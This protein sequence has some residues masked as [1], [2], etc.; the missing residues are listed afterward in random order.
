[1]HQV[2]GVTL[3]LRSAWGRAIK[4]PSFGAK[5]GA[6]SAFA[7][8]LDNP[9][10]GP[11]RQ[12]GWDGGI[13]AVL[14]SRGT[15]SVT[16][17]DQRADNLIDIVTLTTTPTRTTQFQNVG[18]VRN[19]GLEL[20]GTL[21]VGPVHLSGQYGYTRARVEQLAPGYAG[22]QHVG[23]Q[24]IGLPKHTAGASATLALPQGT[25]L[26]AGL[27]YLGSWNWYDWAAFY[28]CLGGTGPCRN[29]TF[30]LGDY[31]MSYRSIV[32]VNATISHQITPFASGFVRIENLTNNDAFEFSNDVEVIGRITTVGVRFGN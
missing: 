17:F 7:V 1:V 13:D 24:V 26:T 22:D 11:E 30:A 21:A 12:Q 16:Y 25:S 8:R 32:K 2:N 27:S 5:V 9:S 15:L 18:R 29:E 31:L 10:L 6:L 28:R 14:G 4:P 20:E 23:A 3:K 19:T